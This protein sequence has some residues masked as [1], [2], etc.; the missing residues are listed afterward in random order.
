MRGFDCWPMHMTPR[1]KNLPCVDQMP[2]NKM[3]N[4][5]PPAPHGQKSFRLSISRN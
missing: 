3:L 4:I 5:D 2:K 1:K